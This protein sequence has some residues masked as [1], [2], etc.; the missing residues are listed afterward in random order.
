MENFAARWLFVVKNR[1]LSR[2]MGII[3]VLHLPRFPFDLGQWGS[4]DRDVIQCTKILRIILGYFV[5]FCGITIMW[6]S[7]MWD[8][9][10]P[11]RHSTK[12]P[13]ARVANRYYR[14][15]II[16]SK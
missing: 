7:I 16:A 10:N 15:I 12:Y 13:L 9:Q 11:L 3:A 5:A 14:P 1:E 6:D 4:G 8:F 2:R